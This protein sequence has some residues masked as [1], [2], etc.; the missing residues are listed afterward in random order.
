MTTPFQILLVE[1]NQPDIILVRQALTEQ[2]LN[3]ELHEMADAEEAVAFIERMGGVPDAPCPDIVLLDLNVPRGEGLE[4]LEAVRTS[5]TCPDVP[6]IIMT[7][8]DSPHDRARATEK[9]C[10]L[11]FKKPIEL[12]QFLKLG[13]L[14]KDVLKHNGTP[15]D[16]AAG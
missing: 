1:D 13:D 15:P 4:L 9:G 7:S 3:F 5:T 6:V 16:K 8:S 14:V 11:Y 12:D 10:T 2:D